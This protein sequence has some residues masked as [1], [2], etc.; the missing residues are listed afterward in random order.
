MTVVRESPGAARPR[1]SEG[2]ARGPSGAVLAIIQS[3]ADPLARLEQAR[4]LL[5]DAHDVDEVKSIADWAEAARVYARQARLGLE[6]QNFAAEIKLRAERRAGELLREMP[7]QGP[8]EYQRFQPGT[9]APR[10]EDLGIKKTQAHRWQKVASVPEDVF[11]MEIQDA[12][13]HGRELTTVEMLQFAPRVS[14]P[15]ILDVD[16][17]AYDFR[18]CIIEQ[19]DTAHIPLPD[20][21]VDLIVTSPPYGLG[22]DYAD[23]DDDQGYLSYFERAAAWA[24]DMYRVAGT[25]GRLCLNVPLDITRGGLK[26]MCADWVNVLRGAGWAYQTTIVWNEG[27]TSKS[28]ARGSV[29]SPSAPHVFARVETII[30]CH[31]G[32]WNLRRIGSHDLAHD[33]WLAWTDGLWS[34]PGEGRDV[35]HPAAFPE[36]L[37]RRCIKMFSFRDAVVCDPFVG[38]GTSAVV[39]HRMGRTFYG[40]D[41][42]AKYVAVA[43]ARVAQAIAA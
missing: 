12:K 10:Y 6:V 11:E 35:G 17:A 37:P 22:I 31:K 38:S 15:V 27:N 14:R 34:F 40:Y 8:G 4:Q 1:S 36:E 39:A 32:E 21:V 19:A 7:K 41:E 2:L 28:I 18:Q 42:S 43:R 16:P 29:D 13:A 25:Q 23:T 33:E 26:P 9:V 3:G 20:G 24:A 5:A 30:V